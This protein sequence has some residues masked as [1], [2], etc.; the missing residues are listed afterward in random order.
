MINTA[1]ENRIPV[2]TYLSEFSEDLIREVILRELD[3][4]GQIFF[5]NNEVFNIEIIADQL[6]RIVP[7]AKVSIAHGQM[8]KNNLEN[9]IKDFTSKQTDI[10]VCTTIIESG[11]DMPNVNT[12]LLYT[13]PSPRD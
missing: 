12:C 5:V 10:L 9:I 13:S 11:I 8:D 3:R 1:P 7:E 6:K 2:N 4:K